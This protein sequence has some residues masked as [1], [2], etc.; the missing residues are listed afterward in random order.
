MNSSSSF[1]YNLSPDQVDAIIETISYEKISTQDKI[2]QIENVLADRRTE[3]QYWRVG[4]LLSYVIL[5]SSLKE[6]IRKKDNIPSELCEDAYTLNLL[7]L[8]FD[9]ISTNYSY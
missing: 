4:F 8:K 9:S 7:L 2:Q 6:E 5:L 1:P 3:F